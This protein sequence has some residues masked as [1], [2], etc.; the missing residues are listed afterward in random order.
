MVRKGSWGL[1]LS[2]YRL[3]FSLWLAEF[4]E[5]SRKLRLLDFNNQHVCL[6][7][8]T[9]LTGQYTYLLLCLV[10]LNLNLCSSIP[11]ENKL[12]FSFGEYRWDSGV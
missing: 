9:L 5:I 4:L 6:Y 1:H 2:V 12:P 11:T 10:F 8:I 3:P 7:L